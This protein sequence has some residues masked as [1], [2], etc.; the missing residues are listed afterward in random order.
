MDHEA[1]AILWMY[2]SWVEADKDMPHSL[3]GA[4]AVTPIGKNLSFPGVVLVPIEGSPIAQ[5]SR[6]LRCAEAKDIAVN[7]DQFPVVEK[8]MQDSGAR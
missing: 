3:D 6:R 7:I 2:A 4:S 8:F 5:A 1:A